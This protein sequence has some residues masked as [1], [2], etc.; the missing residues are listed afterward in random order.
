MG[1]EKILAIEQSISNIR[2]DVNYMQSKLDDLSD[3]KSVLVELKTI[4]EYQVK[5]MD[6]YENSLKSLT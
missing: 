2:E 3:M 5:R 4:S 6:A 1:E